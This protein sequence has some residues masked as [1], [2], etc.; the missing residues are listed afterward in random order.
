MQAVLTMFGAR[1]LIPVIRVQSAR[2][3][4]KNMYSRLGCGLLKVSGIFVSQRFRHSP[5]VR[6]TMVRTSMIYRAADLTEGSKHDLLLEQQ[7]GF[8][9]D[10]LL[11]IHIWS[12]LV[13][14]KSA[15]PHSPGEMFEYR[16][17]RGVAWRGL[18]T[19]VWS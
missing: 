14:N 6:V 18:L 1:V 10:S 16:A 19:F 9:Y 12:K 8:V 7:Q 5:T 11:R 13:S 3:E 2:R 15:K 4:K 17:N